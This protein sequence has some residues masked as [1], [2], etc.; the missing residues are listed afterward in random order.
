MFRTLHSRPSFVLMK[1]DVFGDISLDSFGPIVNTI[2][3]QIESVVSFLSASKCI[4]LEL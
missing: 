3:S 4:L 2:F 1:L